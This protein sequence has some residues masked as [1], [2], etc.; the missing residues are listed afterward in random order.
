MKNESNSVAIAKKKNNNNN[1]GDIGM[2]LKFNDHLL[3]QEL[4]SPLL[5]WNSE[6]YCVSYHTLKNKGAVNIG[7]VRSS[8]APY[9][10]VHALQQGLSMKFQI[11]HD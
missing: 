1:L 7:L 9:N 6:L 4:L 3:S 2:P 5:Y 10:C 8:M 11:L